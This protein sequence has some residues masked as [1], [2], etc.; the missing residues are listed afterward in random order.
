MTGRAENIEPLLAAHEQCPIDGKRQSLCR[1]AACF[2]GVKLFV[3]VEMTLRD[4]S[5][6]E[7]TRSALVPEKI[8]LL[9]RFIPRL[10]RHFL[11]ARPKP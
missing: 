4:S 7:R 3:R 6:D 9:Q 8:A 5:L 2:T 11:L 10:V 1:L